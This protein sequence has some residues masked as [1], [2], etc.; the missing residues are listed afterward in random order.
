MTAETV[1]L[2]DI[3]SMENVQLAGRNIASFVHRTPVISSRSLNEI[4]GQQLFFKCE[5]LQKTGAFKF[6]GAINAI[7]NLDKEQRE[8][9]VVT[10]S[11][12]NHAGALAA[13]AKLFGIKAHIVMPSTSSQVKKAAVIEYGANV[14][15]CEPTLAARLAVSARVQ[16]ETGATMIPP[17]NHPDVIAG[18]ATAAM[19]FH[20]QVDDLD[21]IV[22][23]VGGGGLMSGTCIATRHLKPNCRVIGVEP[24]A[25]DDAF[26]SK[27]SGKIEINE[28]T[29]T[30]ADGLKTSLGE[31]TWPYVRDIV[32][33]VVTVS[34]EEI[35][36]AMKLMFE[37]TKMLIEPS[38]AVCLA[39]VMNS[40]IADV[41][42]RQKIGI[43]ISG[44]NIDLAN[45]PW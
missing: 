17:F 20:D 22:A 24:A 35:V 39:A 43:I 38:S 42:S 16:Q 21:I 33:Q 26:R 19:E 41:N 34:E 27:Q 7:S 40:K 10:H 15:E 4:V 30:I 45:L 18:Q 25:V 29:D 44:G 6:R 31:L 36:V 2:P 28:T 8:K 1:A 23:P 13:A 37:R 14:T 11:S 12:G 5:N 32:E 9:G 3:V